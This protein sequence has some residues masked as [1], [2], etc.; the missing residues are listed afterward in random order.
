M[1]QAGH[2]HSDGKCDIQGFSNSLPRR[3]PG[4]SSGRPGVWR[5]DHF[6]IADKT[7]GTRANGSLMSALPYATV[8]MSS[9]EKK[10]RITRVKGGT[11]HGQGTSGGQAPGCSSLHTAIGM[12][13]AL[14]RDRSDGSASRK[15]S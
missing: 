10:S 6:R 3:S 11:V 9:S 15:N 2:E 14:C 4:S 7:P 8:E 13:P 1:V 5:C 12:F